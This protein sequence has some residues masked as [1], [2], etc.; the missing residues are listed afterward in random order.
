MERTTIDFGIDLGTTNS[1]ISVI[2]GVDT[3]IIPNKVGATV[4][5]SAVWIDKR[6][7]IHV[8]QEAKLRALVEDKENADLEFKLRM[9]MTDEEG[10]KIFAHSG[11]RMTPEELSSEVLKSLKMDVQTCI[12]DQLKSAVIT[13]PAAFENSQ[14]IATK[15]AAQLAGF[16]QCPIL[17]EP[18]AAS[19]AYGFQSE[20]ENVY[21]MVYDFGGGT[22]DAAIM[23]IRDGMI[24]VVNH[25]GDNFLGGKLIDWDIVTKKLVPE[26]QSKFSLSDFR[27]GNSKWANVFGK[28]KYYAEQ[29]KIEVCRTQEAFEIWIENLCEDDNGNCVDFAY[30]LTPEDIKTICTPYINKS[31]K[32]CK[33]TLSKEGINGKD[34]EKVLMVGGTTLNPWI[35]EAIAQ[36][37]QCPLEYSIDP[38][39]VVARGAA[40]FS[41]TQSLKHS[42]DENTPQGAYKIKIEH[43][44]VGNVVD[45]DIGGKVIAPDNTS[46]DGYSIELVDKKTQW[47][48]GRILLGEAGVF[49]TQLYAEKSNR[50]EYKIELCSSTG[51]LVPTVPSQVSYTLGLVTEEPPA[52]MTIGVGLNDGSVAVYVKKGT[53]LPFR[54][55]IDH[56]TSKA[57]RAGV[58]TDELRIPLLEGEHSRA[59]R[60]HGIGVM[61]IKGT[62][63]KHDLPKGSKIEITLLMDSSQQIC[64]QAYVNMLDEDFEVSFNPQM[65]HKTLQELKKEREIQVN[66]LNEAVEKTGDAESKNASDEIR[67]I[68]EQQMQEHVD[69]LIEAAESDKDAVAE[70]DRRLSELASAVDNVE[71]M[72]AYPTILKE[73]SETLEDCRGVVQEHGEFHEKQQFGELEKQYSQAL[74]VK[75]ADLLI[76]LKEELLTLYFVVLGKLP[77]LHVA[78]FQN[79]CESIDTMTDK[80]HAKRIM[81]KGELALQNDDIEGLKAINR[82]LFSLLP[83]DEQETEKNANWGDTDRSI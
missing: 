75:D 37:L 24:Q 2:N 71:D 81:E 20:S 77:E 41:S 73:V 80:E 18:V 9:G 17:L 78:R 51:E 33:K 58:A 47:R 63:I 34:L 54:K 25:D 38:V 83:E 30:S 52:A 44:P 53:K 61:H 27:R 31:L 67:S 56:Y 62:D 10:V 65:K 43:S 8:G 14:T 50:H 1:T 76:R 48:S 57:L 15:K 19:L 79:F 3:R 32:L 42:D 74:E 23:R 55:V 28:L 82:Q 26:L 70:L 39:T 4:T 45:P 40:I 69:S 35:R 59:E 60:N 16:S 46:L 22:F 11:R 36:E 49:M 29:A 12:G 66:R 64:L 13:V 68:K 5:P 72:L 7:G 6:G 21:W